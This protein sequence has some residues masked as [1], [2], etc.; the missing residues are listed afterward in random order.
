MY[1]RSSAINFH[2]SHCPIKGLSHL[3]IA[4]YHCQR[5]ASHLK[6]RTFD[7]AKNFLFQWKS[8]K[9]CCN[10][11][12]DDKVSQFSVNVTKCS[13]MLPV[14]C[15]Q[16]EHLSAFITLRLLCGIGVTCGV[17]SDWKSYSFRIPF[18]ISSGS[19]E[20]KLGLDAYISVFTYW[21]YTYY[22]HS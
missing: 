7:A 20:W 17:I 4:S 18:V 13:Q 8:C 12:F 14:L 2:E 1:L 9:D 19:H 21:Y 10:E 11:G 16:R 5:I 3:S 6:W 22:M 15:Q